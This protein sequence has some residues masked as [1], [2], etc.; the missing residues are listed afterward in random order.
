MEVNGQLHASAALLPGIEP[1]VASEQSAAAVAAETLA[2]HWQV[3]L[4]VSGLYSLLLRRKEMVR[5]II[6]SFCRALAL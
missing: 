1:S 5:P 4:S 3:Q 6:S 2:T